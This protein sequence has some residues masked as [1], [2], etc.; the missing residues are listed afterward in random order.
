MKYSDL[1]IL[2]DSNKPSFPKVE[3]NDLDTLRDTIDKIYEQ[4]KVN[5]EENK[6]CENCA[7]KID[8]LCLSGG[9]CYRG[10]ADGTEDCWEKKE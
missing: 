8:D 10:Y 1:N 4:E 6:L 9:I 5:F 2:R 3:Y 7:N